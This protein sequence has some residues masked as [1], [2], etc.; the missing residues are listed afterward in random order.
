MRYKKEIDLI[1]ELVYLAHT[2]DIFLFDERVPFMEHHLN[3][4]KITFLGIEACG[5]FQAIFGILYKKHKEISD[6]C[7]EKNFENAF[8]KLL[9][10][11]KYDNQSCTS[12]DIEDIYEI[13]LKKEI[14]GSD[15]LY[16][17]FGVKMDSDY[18]CFGD[19]TVYNYHK[20]THLLKKYPY[21][22]NKDIY[23]TSRKSDYLLGIKVKAKDNDKA[24]EVS[25]RLCETFENVF[26]Y[27]IADL[28]HMKSVAVFTSGARYRNKVVI[29]SKDS[30][31][32]QVR[33]QINIPVNINDEYFKNTSNGNDK[34]W[35]L[36]TKTDKS[37]IENRILSSIEW[38]GKAVCDLDNSKAFVQFVFAI[39]GMLQYNSGSIIS[40]SIVSQ[41]SDWLAFILYDNPDHR[42]T[43]PKYFK[44]IY[45]KRSAIAHGGVK[46]IYTEDLNLVLQISKFMIRSFLTIEP[47][48]N[49]KTIKELESY[50]TDLKF[51]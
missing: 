33:G 25:N 27:M 1:N 30:M 48:C 17:L 46:T 29:C 23:F 3:G 4:Y 31:E 26:N 49:F 40:P 15:I 50:L 51:K 12:K 28:R 35:S 21:L 8:L 14:I 38:I 22:V 5:K 32:S 9:I 34:I 13:F 43:I 18:L 42:K 24:I 16:E 20:L 7:S 11:L 19:F 36:I 2:A 10:E 37:E 41:I 6:T 45:Q 44:D 39:E 47:F